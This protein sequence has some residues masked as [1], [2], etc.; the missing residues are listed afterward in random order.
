MAHAAHRHSPGFGRRIPA[1]PKRRQPNC[2]NLQLLLP[3][4]IYYSTVLHNTTTGHSPSTGT[5]PL[6]HPP[7]GYAN[8]AKA[9]RDESEEKV[10]NFKHLRTG[11]FS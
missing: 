3:P 7:R 2:V 5:G 11:V 8:V 9:G 4:K 1:D 10:N 6:Y